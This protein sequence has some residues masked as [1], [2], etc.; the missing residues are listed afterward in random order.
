MIRTKTVSKIQNLET[1][2]FEIEMRLFYNINF[3]NLWLEKKNY[4]SLWINVIF[5]LKE[6]INQMTNPSL[7]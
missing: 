2:T 7:T 1:K 5:N 6:I 3:Q 4:E